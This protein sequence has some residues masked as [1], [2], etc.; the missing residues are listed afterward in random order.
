MT[1]S[2]CMYCK[3]NDVQAAEPTSDIEVE[4]CPGILFTSALM[5]VDCAY[6]VSSTAS[7]GLLLLRLE[8]NKLQKQREQLTLSDLAEETPSVQI[9]AAQDGRGGSAREV[10][11]FLRDLGFSS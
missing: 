9:T 5:C 11:K 1:L 3:R 4:G 6:I 2:Q 8:I 7:K 10:E